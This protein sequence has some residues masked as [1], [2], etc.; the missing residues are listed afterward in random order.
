MKDKEPFGGRGNPDR[1][2]QDGAWANFVSFVVYR[3]GSEEKSQNTRPGPASYG[4]YNL[5]HPEKFC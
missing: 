4:D 3:H 1:S 5:G 2:G